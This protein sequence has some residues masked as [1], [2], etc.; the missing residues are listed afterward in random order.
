VSFTGLHTGK[1]RKQ[2]RDAAVRKKRGRSKGKSKAYSFVWTDDE[3]ELLLKVAI[4][5]KVSKTW[6]LSVPRG[7]SRGVAWI[8]HYDVIVFEKFRFHYPQETRKRSF[9][10]FLL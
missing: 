8:Q 2:F 5:Y 1:A 9:Q 6:D 4:E 10:T 3:V 7:F